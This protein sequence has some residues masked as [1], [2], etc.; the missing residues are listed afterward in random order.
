MVL[1]CDGWY[2]E[3]ALGGPQESLARL[4][5]HAGRRRGFSAPYGRIA[6][7]RPV[8]D[9]GRRRAVIDRRSS[10]GAPVPR[11]NGALRVLALRD[12][13]QIEGGAIQ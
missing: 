13:E 6:R 7:A 10:R 5:V 11:R 12:A 2:Q 8:D 4:S 3:P 1:V 9:A